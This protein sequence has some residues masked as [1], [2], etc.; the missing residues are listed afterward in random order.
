MSIALKIRS[1]TRPI[2]QASRITPSSIRMQSTNEHGQGA[3]HATGQSK[4]P[5]KVQEA[6]PKGLEEALPDKVCSDSSNRPT[7]YY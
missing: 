2:I 1:F 3:S 6:A 4:V 5:G 7:L